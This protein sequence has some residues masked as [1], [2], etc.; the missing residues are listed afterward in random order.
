MA[1]AG[2]AETDE[3]MALEVGLAMLAVVLAMEAAMEALM[4]M[5]SSTAEV[6]MEDGGAWERV[7]VAAMAAE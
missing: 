6:D 5:V 3:K 1:E 2:T 7:V 4:G